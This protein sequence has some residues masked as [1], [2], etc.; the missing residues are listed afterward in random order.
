MFVGG[1]GEQAG[2]CRGL[3]TGDF[4]AADVTGL[5]AETLWS[6]GRLQVQPGAFEH[7]L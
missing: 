7:V 2:K 4:T 5:M 6:T 3:A 1:W